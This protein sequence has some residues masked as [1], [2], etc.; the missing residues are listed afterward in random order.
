MKKL[1]I[2]LVLFLFVFAASPAFAGEIDGIWTLLLPDG[3][4]GTVLMVR[5]NGGTVIAAALDL[6][7]NDWEAY[8]GSLDGTTV[9]LT[10]VLTRWD[11]VGITVTFSSATSATGTITSCTPT[12]A[13][14]CQDVVVGATFTMEKIF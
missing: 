3:T 11:I 6:G 8:V 10:G 4:L 14:Q 2:G 5:E 1:V 9:Q 13:A 12:A 7:M